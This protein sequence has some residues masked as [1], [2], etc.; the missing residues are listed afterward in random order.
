M[1]RVRITSDEIRTAVRQKGMGGLD[2]V[3]AVILETDGR[4]S[5]IGAGRLGSGSAMDGVRGAGNTLQ[6]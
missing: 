5:V 6:E 2:Q 4:P 3:A 1:R